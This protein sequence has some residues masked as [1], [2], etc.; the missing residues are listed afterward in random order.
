MV[1]YTLY[2]KS[3]IYGGA[4]TL[5]KLPEK[6]DP[7]RKKLLELVFSELASFDRIT[8]DILRNRVLDE[9]IPLIID[10]IVKNYDVSIKDYRREE[11]EK[12]LEV[13]VR[14]ILKNKF[15]E[16]APGEYLAVAHLFAGYLLETFEFRIRNG[17]ERNV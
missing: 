2:H 16:Y 5:F 8:R 12:E 14:D 10:H 11:G 15:P 13:D 6:Y 7:V 4:T 1:D 17:G 9:G 3:V